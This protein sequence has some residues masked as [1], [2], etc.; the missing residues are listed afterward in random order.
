MIRLSRA[1]QSILLTFSF[2]ALEAL[3]PPKKPEMDPKPAVIDEV[4][5]EQSDI[6]D[7]RATPFAGGNF[8]D[9]GFSN[10][11]DDDENDWEDEDEDSAG[12]PECR[13]Q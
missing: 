13:P 7:V 8:F 11:F 3:L 6:A 5:F 12:E 10:Q 4:D 9:H 2:Q 1:F